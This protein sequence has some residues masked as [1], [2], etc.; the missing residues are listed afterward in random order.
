MV[1]DVAS[2]KG[3][4]DLL[5]S[6]CEDFFKPLN[7]GWMWRDWND[8]VQGWGVLNSNGTAKWDFGARLGC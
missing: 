7:I 2:E 3:F 5:D 1:A 4:W 6:H 8:V